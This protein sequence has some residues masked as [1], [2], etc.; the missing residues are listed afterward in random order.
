MDID[1]NFTRIDAQELRQWMDDSKN[2]T[3]LDVLPADVHAARHIPGAANACVFEVVFPEHVAAA[4]CT[5]EAEAPVVV[6]GEDGETRDAE[7]AAKKLVRLGF[8]R[9]YLLRGGIAD[10]LRQELPVEGD[11]ALP[12]D[13]RPLPPDGTYAVDTGESVIEWAGRNMNGKHTGTLALSQGTLRIVDGKIGGEF[14][15][16]LDSIANT[17][18]EDPS[19]ARMLV[20]HLLSD[21]FFFADR[22][23]EALFTVDESEFIPSATPGVTNYHVRGELTLRGRAEVLAFPLTVQRTEDGIAAEAHFDLDRTRWGAVY[24]SGKLFRRLGMHL[25]NDMVSIQLRVVAK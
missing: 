21:D 6:Y 22:Y 16:R 5:P 4:G 9:V 15:L 13:H 1:T 2:F 14:A 19:L 3:L 11:G 20:A 24:G 7:M 18:L 10:W 25:V 12:E 8:T 23:P 17:D